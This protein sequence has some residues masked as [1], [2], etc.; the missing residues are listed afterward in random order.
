MLSLKTSKAIPIDL[1][2]TLEIEIEAEPVAAAL[3]LSA[4]AFLTLLEQ[5]KIDQ[6]CER[7]TGIDTGL[8]RA[9][10]YYQ[11]TRARVIIDREGRLQSEVEIRT[12]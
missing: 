8:Y 4:D 5:R 9:S 6:L 7:G 1:N 11:Q 2:P 10:Y 12:R 3:G